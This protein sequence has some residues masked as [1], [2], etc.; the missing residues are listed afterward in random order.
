LRNYT[1]TRSVST[2]VELEPGHYSVLIK[3]DATR[4]LKFPAPED[5]VRDTCRSRR[6]KLLQIGLSYDL[7]H[8][9]GQVKETEAE[10]KR[11]RQAR[12][13]QKR[14]QL[15]K[16]LAAAREARAKQKRKAK[17]RAARKAAR[18][19]L[20]HPRNHATPHRHGEASTRQLDVIEQDNTG[21]TV[22]QHFILL[23]THSRPKP[24]ASAKDS[25][26]SDD[27]SERASAHARCNANGIA[28]AEHDADAAAN[29]HVAVGESAFE[30]GLVAR[31]LCRHGHG[32]RHA[33]GRL[34][35][36]A[37]E[38]Q[39]DSRRGSIH[40][41]EVEEED[42]D[43]ESVTSSMF[44]ESVATSDSER[45]AARSTAQYED[46]FVKAPWNAVCVVGLR[47][48][49]KDQGVRIEVVRPRGADTEQALDPDDLAAD[50]AKDGREPNELEKSKAE[51]ASD[52]ESLPDIS[53]LAVEL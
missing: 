20:K 16:E 27:R 30:E 50:A 19:A 36:E 2:E 38:G 52:A 40:V 22:R 34:H 42:S 46:D 10:K 8:A 37:G 28:E 6:E 41:G 48:Y 35:T 49:S 47:V 53:A 45:S 11:R 26:V 5:V 51:G 33:G 4:H 23:P 31:G 14:E 1:L 15:R 13:A 7:A 9:K 32:P 29:G 44:I 3:V 17:E 24:L 43:D 39:A 21:Q 18:N 12:A 25:A